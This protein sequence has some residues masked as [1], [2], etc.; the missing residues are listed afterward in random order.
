MSK[1]AKTRQSLEEILASCSDSLFPAEMGDAEVRI[2]RRD[3]EGDTPLHV[4]VWRG[5]TYAALLLIEAGADV[6]AVGDMS[7]TPLHVAVSKENERVVEAL[8]NAG[9][10]PNLVSEFGKTPRD[11]ADERGRDLKRCFT[12]R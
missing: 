5:D 7:E 3:V 12:N 9:A 11:L 1:K 10:N 4:M 2:D 8:L 6:N